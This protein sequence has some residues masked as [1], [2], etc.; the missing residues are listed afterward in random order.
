VL[1]AGVATGPG[2]ALR[3]GTTP[4]LPTLPVLPTQ[5]GATPGPGRGPAGPTATAPVPSA[6]AGALLALPGA[7]L[8]ATPPDGVLPPVGEQAPL[9]TAAGLQRV[10]GPLLRRPGLGGS[11]SAEVVDLVTGRRLL[12]TAPTRAATPAS[13]AK[14]LTAAAALSLLG[15]SERLRTSVVDGTTRDEVVL[16]GGGD[17]VLSEGRS[18]EDAVVG[19]AGLATLAAD[20]A[21]ALRAEGRASVAVRLDDS[22]FDPPTVDP[23]WASDVGAGY[24]APVTALAVNAGTADARAALDPA[25]SYRR[26]ADP[27]LAAARTFARLLSRQGVRVTGS[28]VRVQAPDGAT[29]LA[30][31]ESATVGDLVEHALTDSDNTVAEALARLVAARSGRRATFADAGV[32]VL[33]RVDLL[34]V[35][36]TGATLN[37]GSGLGGGNALS[38][39]T[40]A[41]LL[42]LAASP[43]HPELRPLLSGLPVAGASGTLVDRFSTAADRGALGM[44]RAKTGTLTG[45]SSLAG[46]AVDA[47]GRA[48]GFVILADDVASTVAARAALDDAAAALAGCGCR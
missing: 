48:L 29:T 24:V 25:R 17:V 42:V 18:R 26:L 12:S 11:V 46:M 30:T 23:S 35:P 38:A 39:R 28:V 9:P 34:G 36:T 15:P 1:L 31:A 5:A 44:V 41:D 7:T 45:V 3:S 21:R 43:D 20:T 47:D 14:L 2:D 10:L 19:H 37:G 22:L 27:A 6:A 33:D 32:A 16:V 13:T 40:L 4:T 8:P